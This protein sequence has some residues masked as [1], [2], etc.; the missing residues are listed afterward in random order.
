MKRIV[1]LVRLLPF[2]E[3]RVLKPQ[4][5]Q[6]TRNPYKEPN[7]SGSIQRFADGQQEAPKTSFESHGEHTDRRKD[8]ETMQTFAM[9]D[10]ETELFSLCIF[11]SLLL[12]S[13]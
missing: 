2:I 6:N 3:W 13:L 7:V 8:M 4:D 9:G 12:S 10:R 5:V 11:E 1:S